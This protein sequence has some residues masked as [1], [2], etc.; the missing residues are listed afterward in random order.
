MTSPQHDP[1]QQQY[2][3]QPAPGPYSP[4]PY[5]PPAPTPGQ[6]PA[7]PV[8]GAAPAQP[9][10]GAA[11]AQPA[12][13]AAPA[14]PGFAAA[15]PGYQQPGQPP[16]PYQPPATYQ[17]PGQP[18]PMYQQ[19]GAP[20][21]Y[22]PPAA[23]TPF[24]PRTGVM[25][26]IVGGLLALCALGGTAA[27]FIVEKGLPGTAADTSHR[28]PSDPCQLLSKETLGTQLGAPLEKSAKGGDGVCNYTFKHDSRSPEATGSRLELR[29]DVSSTAASK[30]QAARGPAGMTRLPVECGQGGFAGH[31][32]DPAAENADAMLWCLDQDV[33]LT[34]TFHGY[35]H[36][37]FNSLELDEVMA[38]LG[39]TALANVPKGK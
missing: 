37:R 38:G 35:N 23:A 20:A 10:S 12:Y 1:F 11:P 4:A 9:M 13:G 27:A 14:Q 21:A 19:P 18:A 28:Q 31:K 6:P 3:G 8:S 36:D 7:Q 29:V 30:F 26:A 15:P 5:P 2:P 39:R 16:A 25:V 22:Q 34:L 32:L 17:Q 24:R 33:F